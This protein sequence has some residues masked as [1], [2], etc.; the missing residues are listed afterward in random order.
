[1]PSPENCGAVGG[2]PHLMICQHLLNDKDLIQCVL[3]MI[4]YTLLAKKCLTNDLM[5]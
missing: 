3:V 1:M 5:Q 2:I 4:H